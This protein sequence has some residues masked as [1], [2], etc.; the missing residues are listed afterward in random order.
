MGMRS[1]WEQPNWFVLDG[2]E[3]GYKPSFRRTNWFE[4]VGRECDLVLNKVGVIDLS[5]CA[6][7]EVTGSGAGSFL[8]VIFANELPKVRVIFY[9]WK[10]FIENTELM[11]AFFSMVGFYASPIYKKS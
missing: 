2:D 4:P 10:K 6:K 9:S 7:I 8:D 11:M 5:P 1:G 3:P